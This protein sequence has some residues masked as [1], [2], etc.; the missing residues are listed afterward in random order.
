[1]DALILQQACKI[2][3]ILSGWDRAGFRGN[4]RMLADVAGM[5]AAFPTG[6]VRGGGSWSLPSPA[7]K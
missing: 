7:D 4:V 5:G 1:M 3:G 6:V 2:G